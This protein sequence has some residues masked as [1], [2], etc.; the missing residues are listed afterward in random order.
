[1][2]VVVGA[3]V[4]AMAVVVAQALTDAR[5]SQP[6]LVVRDGGGNAGGW[7]GI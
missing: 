2:V 7:S 3:V 1:M 5:V 6:N 4:V